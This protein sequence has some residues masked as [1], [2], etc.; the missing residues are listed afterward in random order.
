[1]AAPKQRMT[2]EKYVQIIGW[3]KENKHRIHHSDDSQIDVCRQAENTLGFIVPI[4]SIQKCGKI[5]KIRWPKSPT[6]PAPVPLEREAII[7]LMGTIAG[8]YVETGRSVPTELANLQSTYVREQPEDDEPIE[9][10]I[11]N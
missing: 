1:M 8:L 6:P 3:L 11:D 5:A 10:E 2:L 7:I 9:P 4:T